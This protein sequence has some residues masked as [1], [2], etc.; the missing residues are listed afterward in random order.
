MVVSLGQFLKDLDARV[1]GTL[2]PKWLSKP[3]SVST[4]S[5]SIKKGEVFWA[6]RGAQFDGHRFVA[7]SL[8][9]GAMGA[10]VEEA[11]AKKHSDGGVLFL[12]KNTNRSLLE[13]ANAYGARFSIPKVA[14]TGSNGKTTTKEMIRA[15]L[16]KKGK[17]LAT[18]KNFNNQF[19]LPFT[20]FRLDRS[21]RFAVL[22]MG[23]NTP[24]EIEILSRTAA[25]GIGVITNVSYNHLQAFKSLQGVFREKTSLVKGLSR[26]GLCILNAEDPLLATFKPPRGIRKVTFG[27][28]SGDV[29]PSTLWHD[30]NGRATFQYKGV[31]IKLR[32]PGVHNV[33]NALAAI[34]V[35]EACG[36]S[37]RKMQ[38]ALEKFSTTG[39]RLRVHR[40]GKLKVLDDC[41]NA[42][43]ASMQAA[44]Q[45][46]NAS[47]KGG[48]RYAV[49]GD[50]LELGKKSPDLHSQVGKEVVQSGVQRLYTFGPLAKNIAEGARKAGM[51]KGDIRH[52]QRI[53]ALNQR[54]TRDL[55]RGGWVLVKGSRGMRLE[56]V[57]EALKEKFHGKGKIR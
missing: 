2:P 46:L 33:Y 40:W 38:E 19:G 28:E 1:T 48:E 42:S 51:A 17:V 4:D 35:G 41:Y 21:H 8:S 27:L 32:V 6:L 25:A 26:P 5:R 11:W 23:T 52:Y 54:L 57:S 13:F 45:T 34:A 24:G 12:V 7:Q 56:R 9:R 14:V 53:H 55:Q 18:E 30:A 22:E 47:S 31:S 50:M 10:V 29:R 49:L 37:L 16:A 39:R 36:V 43:P 44:L 20:L 3:L 15:V